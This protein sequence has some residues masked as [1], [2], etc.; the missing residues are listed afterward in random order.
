MTCV[1]I[2]RNDGEYDGNH[3]ENEPDEGF[4]EN[5]SEFL[6]SCLQV[7]IIEVWITKRKKKDVKQ[8]R[9]DGIKSHQ[10]RR[11]N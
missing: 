10:E 2:Y 3:D 1:S 4:M 5:F 6:E 9:D 8:R 7:F 11:R